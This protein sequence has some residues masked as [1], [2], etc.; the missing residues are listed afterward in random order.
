MK[1]WLDDELPMPDGYDQHV[2]TSVEAIALLVNERV[3]LISLDHDLG[4]ERNGSGYDVAKFIEQAA[5]MGTISP[6]VVRIHSANPVGRA[7][8][9]QA[10]ARAQEFW[11]RRVYSAWLPGC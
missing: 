2:K 10:I 7:R 3:R 5:Y 8:M 6:I 9:E 4:E 1:V 11:A